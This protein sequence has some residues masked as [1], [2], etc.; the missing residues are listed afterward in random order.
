MQRWR[1]EELAAFHSYACAPLDVYL[2]RGDIRETTQLELESTAVNGLLNP[3]P[4]RPI[5]I[6]KCERS[7][8]QSTLPSSEMDRLGRLVR[9]NGSYPLFGAALLTYNF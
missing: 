3:H 4:R 9:S 5:Q 7:P 1:N 8:V 2:V 6:A